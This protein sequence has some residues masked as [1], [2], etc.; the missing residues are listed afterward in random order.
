MPR[1]CAIG[2]TTVV[3]NGAAPRY[4]K[5]FTRS[6]TSAQI[7]HD[8]A[9]TLEF[10]N[11]QFDGLKGGRLQA[12]QA[13]LPYWRRSRTRH[14]PFTFLEICYP[15]LHVERRLSYKCSAKTIAESSNIR[16]KWLA[17]RQYPSVCLRRDEIKESHAKCTVLTYEGAHHFESRLYE[18]LRQVDGWHIPPTCTI[19]Y[20][21]ETKLYVKNEMEAVLL[22]ER[23]RF[24]QYAKVGL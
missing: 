14:L 11:K 8:L 17:R 15:R 16:C 24:C 12:R 23:P 18:D 19:N 2:F 22:L 7:V 3:V 9:K 10:V 21:D 6:Y 20:D 13:H 4:E 5:K 1:R